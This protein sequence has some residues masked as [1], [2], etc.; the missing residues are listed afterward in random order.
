[1][2]KFIKQEGF[3]APRKA[4]KGKL[5][6]YCAAKGGSVTKRKE[7]GTS[8]KVAPKGCNKGRGFR[9]GYPVPY[10]H[11]PGGLAKS[12]LHGGDLRYQT[13]YI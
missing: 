8:S 7:K 11:S 5:R 4:G 1:M 10:A 2:K 12:G 6:F 13:A 3:N 9:I